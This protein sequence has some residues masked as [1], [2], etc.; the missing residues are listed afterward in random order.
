[1]GA[2]R[3]GRKERERKEKERKR[4]GR[5]EKEKGKMKW[6]KEERKW[7]KRERGKKG[8]GERTPAASAA[9]VGHAWRARARE[10]WGSR[11]ASGQAAPGC[12][13]QGGGERERKR[14]EIRG[15]DRDGW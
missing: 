2:E 15:D 7:K 4:K 14:R 3:E 10:R 12:T 11:G 13:R 5:K 1:L 8:E 6:R 9:A